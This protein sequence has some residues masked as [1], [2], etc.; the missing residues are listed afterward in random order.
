VAEVL[1][2]ELLVDHDVRLVHRSR[3]DAGHDAEVGEVPAVLLH[4]DRREP[5]VAE[6]D[7]ELG[8]DLLGEPMKAGVVVGHRGEDDVGFEVPR[9]LEGEHLLDPEVALI[10]AHAGVL[11]VGVA[12]VDAG[13]VAPRLEVLLGDGV[14]VPCLLELPEVLMEP[15]HPDGPEKRPAEALTEEFQRLPEIVMVI[16]GEQGGH[17]RSHGYG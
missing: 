17:E 6:V 3:K 16:V 15:V 14:T 7:A 1:E 11:S 13:V 9:S 5:D 2:R 12:E 10:E 8:T 4:V